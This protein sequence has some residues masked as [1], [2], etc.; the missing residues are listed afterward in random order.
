MGIV[1]QLIILIVG[2]IILGRVGQKLGF[3]EVVGQLVAGII[4]GPAILHWV[5]TGE[6]ISSLSELGVLLL[7]FTAGLETDVGQLRRNLTGATLTAVMGVVVPLLLFTVVTLILG[8]HYDIAIF[9]GIVFA[10]TSI[11]ITISVLGEA[12]QLGS[13]VGAVVLGA[14][15]LDD[16]LALLL[17]GAYVLVFGGE[18]L[19]ISTL[20]PIIVFIIGL[21]VNRLASSG[22]ILKYSNL[23]GV[24]FFF[25]IFFG[26]IGLNISLNGLQKT[27]PLIIVL[28][29][30][31][32]AT[33]YYGAQWGARIA[34]L[35]KPA[36]RA[37][38]AG[39][40]SRGEMAL[41]VAQIGL[42]ANLIAKNIFG[43]M[44]IVIIV[45]TIIA[46]LMLRP[47]LKRI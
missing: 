3:A 2:T 42:S 9:W 24:W 20:L 41:V 35:D 25:P 16:M 5:A 27:W 46:P 29:V 12:G 18:G 43:D 47:L 38:G 45:S 34:K 39:M 36:A 11:S 19:S 21:I 26:S 22:K 4:M 8:Y 44:V 40:V 31:A 37:V 13:Q 1:V 23:L 28:T 33:K 15:V 17:V 10:A 32:V 7:M 6:V 30:L 14:A